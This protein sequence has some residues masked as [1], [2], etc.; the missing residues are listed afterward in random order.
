MVPAP[1]TAYKDLTINRD[2]G[3]LTVYDMSQ[4]EFLK[5][6]NENKYWNVEQKEDF[7]S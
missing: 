3:I 5:F 7:L 6:Y 4:R 1:V 2:D